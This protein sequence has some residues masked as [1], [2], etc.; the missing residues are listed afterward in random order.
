MNKV[1][2]F[3]SNMNAQIKKNRESAAKN[4]RRNRMLLRC[5]II[6]VSVMLFSVFLLFIAGVSKTT[7]HNEIFL[8]SLWSLTVLDAFLLAIVLQDLLDKHL[9]TTSYSLS[10]FTLLNWIPFIHF[11]SLEESKD[12]INIFTFIAAISTLAGTVIV[13]IKKLPSDKYG[14]KK[15]ITTTYKDTIKDG[16]IVN[17]QKIGEKV[18]ENPLLHTIQGN[19]AVLIGIKFLIFSVIFFQFTNVLSVFF[20]SLR[21]IALYFP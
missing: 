10:I 8:R 17:R 6:F 12:L 20:I 11:R 14:V 15:I 19:E 16:K 4:E 3:Y 1:G 21:F 13:I 7:L 18:Q 5:A 9:H 2:G